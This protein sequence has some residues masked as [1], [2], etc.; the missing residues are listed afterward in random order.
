[1]HTTNHSGVCL[2]YVPT[3]AYLW[4]LVLEFFQDHTVKSAVIFCNS[5]HQSQHLRDHLERKLNELQLNVDVL[6]INGLLHKTD[7]FWR[8]CLFYD[9]GHIQ[10][11]NF[12]VLVT[13]NA[14]N[15]GI[16]KSHIALQV[17]LDWLRDLP[18]YFQERG[19]R[20]R[21]P[22]MRSACV[23]YADLS[24]YVFLLCQLVNGSEHSVVIDD[25]L[26]G[27]CE[28]FNS[29]ISPRR[30]ATR[31]TNTSQEDFALRPFRKE[32]TSRLLYRRTRS[33]AFLLPRL[34]MSARTRRSVSLQWLSWFNPSNGAMHFVSYMQP[35]VS[36]GFPSGVLKRCGRLSR[37]VDTHHQTPLYRR[38]EDT[39][40]L[41]AHDE[42]LL[43]GDTLQ[44][45]VDAN[46][47]NQ[48]WF[49]V[50]IIGSV[51]NRRNTE[52][53]WWNQV[54]AWTSS[55]TNRTTDTDRNVALIHATIG[56]AKYT[57][58]EYWVGINLHPVTRIRVRTLA[59]PTP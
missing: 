55:A 57:L 35:E 51:W 50:L 7:K 26:S 6:H 4:Y 3:L 5:R 32:T 53:S 1:M 11:A 24:S 12:W 29:A 15:V 14:A 46:Y 28:G 25:D 48:W 43:E 22:G 38:Q 17:Q 45:V 54:Y 42:H 44:Q 39:C 21:Q 23:L 49:S 41:V 18:T 58:G 10:E 59:I 36:Q 34:G 13:T 27:Q 30:A 31:Q 47:S 9:E 2:W 37:V 33:F 19:H 40:I 8:I 56:M 20:S 16:D 52:Q